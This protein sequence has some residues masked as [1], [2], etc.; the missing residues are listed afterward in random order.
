[1]Q[2]HAKVYME[3]LAVAMLS[4]QDTKDHKPLVSLDTKQV[5]QLFLRFLCAN[6]WEKMGKPIFKMITKYLVMSCDSR[7]RQFLK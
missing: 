5:K 1:M 2:V 4:R 6:Y 3:S 7:G